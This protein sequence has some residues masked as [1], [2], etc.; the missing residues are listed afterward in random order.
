MHG[1]LSP[2]NGIKAVCPWNFSF[3]KRET[4]CREAVCVLREG[5]LGMND[6]LSFDN[7]NGCL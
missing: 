6:L 1:S 5:G 4:D 3:R 2:R 7:I